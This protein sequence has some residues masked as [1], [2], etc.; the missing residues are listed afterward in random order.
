MYKITILYR[1]WYTSS[2]YAAKV[3]KLY[4]SL[5]VSDYFNV[6]HTCRAYGNM[7]SVAKT[8]GTTHYARESINE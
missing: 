6:T 3:R 4:H 2:A 8:C 7:R 1:I 5:F